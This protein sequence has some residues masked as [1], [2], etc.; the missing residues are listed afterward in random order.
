MSPMSTEPPIPSTGDQ[1][2]VIDQ[3]LELEMRAFAELLLDIYEWR[4]YN[5]KHRPADSTPEQS[6]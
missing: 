6:P 5:R 3:Q 2:F 1:P 4:Y